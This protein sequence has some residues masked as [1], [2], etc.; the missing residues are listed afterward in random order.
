ML[1]ILK[2]LIPIWSARSEAGPILLLT[3]VIVTIITATPVVVIMDVG[4]SIVLDPKGAVVTVFVAATPVTSTAP[5][6][7]SFGK[8]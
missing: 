5:L 7:D 2:L 1:F 6:T 8:R 4:I 3:Q